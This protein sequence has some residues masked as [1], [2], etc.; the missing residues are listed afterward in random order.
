MFKYIVAL[1][2]L[3]ALF[4]GG[5]FALN[6][7]IYDT[8]FTPLDVAGYLTGQGGASDYKNATYF[9][10]DKSVTLA[11]GESVVDDGDGWKTET[12]YFGNLA[13]G[14]LNDDGIP[15][16]AFIL[17]QNGGG[18]GTFFYAVVAFQNS[19]GR[20]SGSNAI[21]L[22]DRVAPQT[23]EIRNGILIVNYMDRKPDEPFSTP[24]S[25]GVSTYIYYDGEKLVAVPPVGRITIE[26]TMVCLPHKDTE[27]PQTTE[28]AFGLH[29]D[30]DRYF[31]LS[32]TDP[33]YKNVSGVP[34]NARVHVEGN[35]KLH[36][37]SKYQD[38]GVIDVAKIT[39]L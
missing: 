4:V 18:S 8:K 34:M 15:D 28:C 20:Y 30:F 35:F 9:I 29:D 17:T 3:I 39:Q 38:I 31:A 13:K 23:A 1:G 37:G 22:G 2:I 36:V 26:G 12:K 6:H 25:V 27:G 21:L 24:L 32:D 16:I 10:Q 33:S 11:N 7:Y 5:F 14:D 19:V